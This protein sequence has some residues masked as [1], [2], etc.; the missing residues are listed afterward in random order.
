[1]EMNRLNLMRTLS[2]PPWLQAQLELRGVATD[3]N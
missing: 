3:F 2:L 1:M